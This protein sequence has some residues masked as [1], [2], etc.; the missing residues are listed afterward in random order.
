M[1]QSRQREENKQ[2]CDEK[3]EWTKDTI[4]KDIAPRNY[5]PDKAILPWL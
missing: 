3:Y 5:Y 1:L 4:E 2:T